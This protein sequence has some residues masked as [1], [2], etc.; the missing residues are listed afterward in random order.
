MILQTAL[1]RIFPLNNNIDNND[2]S[3]MARI[4]PLNNNIDNNNIDN[5]DTLDCTGQ[6]IS[7]E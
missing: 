5:N 4:Y 7:V 6:N 3:M 2:L 1:A